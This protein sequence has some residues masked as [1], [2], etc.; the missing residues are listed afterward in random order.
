ME[1]LIKYL[2]QFGNFNSHQV[3]LIQQNVS[4]RSL[5]KGEY[6]SEAGKIAKE[7]AF[8]NKGIFRVCYYNKEGNKITKY[9]LSRIRKEIS[10]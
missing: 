5:K 6:F 1:S 8:I 2:L 4:V 9:S 3:N 10:K 7:I